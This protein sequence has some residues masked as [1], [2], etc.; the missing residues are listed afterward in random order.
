[1]IKLKEFKKIEEIKLLNELKEKQ[2]NEV[3]Y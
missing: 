3:I 1:M 2:R